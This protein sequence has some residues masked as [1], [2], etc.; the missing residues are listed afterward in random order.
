MDAVI[1]PRQRQVFDKGAA[2]GLSTVSTTFASTAYRI[3]SELTGTLLRVRVER[4]VS[5]R[6]MHIQPSKYGASQKG[7]PSHPQ[8]LTRTL[9]RRSNLQSRCCARVFGVR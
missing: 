2:P 1:T 4:H 8:T 3:T 6:A 7:R 5:H 9:L